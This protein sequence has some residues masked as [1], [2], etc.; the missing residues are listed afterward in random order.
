MINNR[1]VELMSK[2]AL[3][4]HGEGKQTIRLNKYFKQDYASTNLLRSAPLGILC[5][6]LIL[7]LLF[8]AMPNWITDL[9]KVMG[10]PLAIIAVIVAIALFV[11]GYCFFSQY[12]FNHKF[13]NFRGNL[14]TYGIYLKRLEKIYDEEENK[15]ENIDLQT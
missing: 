12:M 6:V 8:I 2:I 4:E 1:K 9:I 7:V 14:R 15:K 10:G 11:V 5:A 3:Y 13:E